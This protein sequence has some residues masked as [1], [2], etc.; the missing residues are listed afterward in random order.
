MAEAPAPGIARFGCGDAVSNSAGHAEG[1][2]NPL[3]LHAASEYS[4]KAIGRTGLWHLESLGVWR[5][6]SAIAA[7]GGGTHSFG[8]GKCADAAG[9]E[10]RERTA[11]VGGGNQQ[12]AGLQSLPPENVS[13]HL[14]ERTATGAARLPEHPAA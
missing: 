9:A 14:G 1:T 11:A 8:G 7:A 13:R 5:K 10:G 6:R 3:V 12:F 4:P 2:R